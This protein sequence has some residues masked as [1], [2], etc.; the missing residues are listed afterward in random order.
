MA[1]AGSMSRL[2]RSCGVS[3]Q[4]VRAWV[5]RGEI[6]LNRVIDV[7]RATGLSLKTFRPDYF[8]GK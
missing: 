1:K 4:A 5:V 7:K 8:G 2:A 6:P 3:P